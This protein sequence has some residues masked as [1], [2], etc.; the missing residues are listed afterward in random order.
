MAGLLKSD[1]AR[2]R[3]GHRRAVRFTTGL[4]GSCGAPQCEKGPRDA[5]SGC[6]NHE[7]ACF[8]H[9]ENV[10]AMPMPVHGWLAASLLKPLDHTA[11][12][13]GDIPNDCVICRDVSGQG[14]HEDSADQPQPDRRGHGDCICRSLGGSTGNGPSRFARPCSQIISRRRGPRKGT[15]RPG[16]GLVVRTS[17]IGGAE[18]GAYFAYPPHH[19]S[20]ECRVIG[21]PENAL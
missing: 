16:R 18:N 9:S 10:F 6:P 2:V 20:P 4:G 3:R 11:I 1:L 7:D 15:T 12:S 13:L 17:S 14:I 8:S 21:F 19:Y 5:R